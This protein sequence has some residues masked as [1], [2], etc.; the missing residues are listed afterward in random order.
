M[1][2]CVYNFKKL[3]FA[4]L[5]FSA[6]ISSRR[7][8]D[9]MKLQFEFSNCCWDFTSFS[10]LKVLQR[11][12]S[13]KDTKT[14]SELLLHWIFFHTPEDSKVFQIFTSWCTRKGQIISKGLFGVL[15][16]SKKTNERIR[17]SSKNEFVRSFF[18]NSRVPK[19]LSKLSDL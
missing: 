1:F 10:K 14:T 17:C 6:D 13:W 3:F 2:L 5:S 7:L 12:I 8:F 15:E 16:F 11:I 9:T 19:V 4:K 18:L